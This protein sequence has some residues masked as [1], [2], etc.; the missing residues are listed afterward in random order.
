M[1]R[2]IKTFLKK[3]FRE[4]I[5]LDEA[6][7]S[8]QIIYG[9]RSIQKQLGVISRPTEDYDIFTK[10]PKSSATKVE[11]KLD[12]LYGF[13]YHYTKKGMHKGTY[14]VKSRGYDLK[15][16]TKDDE[17][18]IDYTKMPPKAPRTILSNGIRYRHIKEEIRGKK[19]TLKDKEF[20][21]RH[22]KDRRDLNLINTV[23]RASNFKV[24]TKLK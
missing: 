21:F 6:K 22:E 10:N 23:I 16:G 8:N 2:Q 4:K 7:N 3:P 20:A 14:K 13:D 11:K 19:S 12:K 18:I 24:N 17:G 9:A 1:R 5:I 15:K